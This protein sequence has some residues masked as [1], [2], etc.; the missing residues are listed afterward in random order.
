VTISNG[1]GS[2]ESIELPPGAH[3]LQSIGCPAPHECFVSQ[4]GGPSD[5]FSG[6]IRTTDDWE[7]WTVE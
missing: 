4:V 7:T 5:D 6:F 2:W 1:D 3:E